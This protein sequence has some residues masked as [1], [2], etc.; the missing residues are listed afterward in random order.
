[1]RMLAGVLAL[2][3]SAL[4]VNHGSRSAPA[5]Q[6]GVGGE[7]S[8][9]PG[10]A[11]TRTLE[12]HKAEL[13]ALSGGVWIASNADYREADGGMDEYGLAWSV[14]PG[15]VSASGC[16]WGLKGG[17]VTQ[18]FWQF[19]QGWDPTREVAIVYQSHPAGLIGIGTLE[20]RGEGEPELVQDF[21]TP[22][23]GMARNGHFERWDGTDRRISQS[24]EWSDDRWVPRR[25]YTW[26][27]DRNRSSPC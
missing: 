8:S 23:S 14:Q 21:W 17:E 16:L 22:G 18:V 5:A 19:F 20:D 11:A 15:G 26:V 4:F 6:E 10:P 2:A 12:E 3:S 27:R 24:V 1:M 13:A 25:S 9:V 7:R